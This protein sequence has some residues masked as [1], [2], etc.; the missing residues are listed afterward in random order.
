MNKMP[1]MVN[2]KEKI[3]HNRWQRSHRG[4][5]GQEKNSILSGMVT[6]NIAGKVTLEQRHRVDVRASRA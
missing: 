1:D 5:M 6:E 2:V 3:K 4:R